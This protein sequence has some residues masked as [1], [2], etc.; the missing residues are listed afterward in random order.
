MHLPVTSKNVSWP[1]LIW[2]TLYRTSHHCCL[3]E[4]VPDF[5]RSRESTITQL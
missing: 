5:L 4:L 2:P 1:R 3:R